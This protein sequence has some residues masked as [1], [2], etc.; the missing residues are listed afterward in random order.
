M[1]IFKEKSSIK[2]PTCIDMTLNKGIKLKPTFGLRD[3]FFYMPKNNY[4]NIINYPV[5][6]KK[7]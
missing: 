5:L 3:D 1:S 7:I 2:L 4:I 6:L